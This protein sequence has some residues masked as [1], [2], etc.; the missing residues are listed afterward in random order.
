[1]MKVFTVYDVKAEAYLNPFIM[2]SKGEATR[3]FAD[4]ANRED[5]SIG[6]HPQDYVLFELGSFDE[7]TGK[8][9]LHAA[10]ESL[11]VALEYVQVKQ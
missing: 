3:G 7:L 6:K 10:P 4:E 5:S 8:F 11:G 2:R 9:D 1:M